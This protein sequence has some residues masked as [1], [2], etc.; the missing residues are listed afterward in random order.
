M[1]DVRRNQSALGND[2]WQRLIAAIDAIRRPSANK[3]RY[4]DFVAVHQ[5]GMDPDLTE[6][7]LEGGGAR[8]A[9]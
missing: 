7:A 6:R 1:A 2:D 9:S 8:V 5:A 3:P 4:Q